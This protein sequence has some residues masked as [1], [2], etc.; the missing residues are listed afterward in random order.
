MNHPRYDKIKEFLMIL[1]PKHEKD[2][3]Y[4]KRYSTMI[5]FI[6][7][8]TI[9]KVAD[10][11]NWDV[12]DLPI[13]ID[14]TIAIMASNTLGSFGLLDTAN[15]TEVANKQQVKQISEGDVTVSFDTKKVGSDK[16]SDALG[17]N[18]ITSN[19][20]AQLMHYRRLRNWAI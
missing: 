2:D 14:H 8:D 19:H 16:L 9:Q 20:K 15:E 17:A 11:I 7:A 10:F 13:S 3:E 12:K 6:L 4:T 1:Q 18:P 5:D